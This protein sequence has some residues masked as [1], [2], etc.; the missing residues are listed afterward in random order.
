MKL[1]AVIVASLRKLLFTTAKLSALKALQAFKKVAIQPVSLHQPDDTALSGHHGFSTVKPCLLGSQRYRFPHRLLVSI[2][3]F[4]CSSG[5]FMKH[6][7]R[8]QVWVSE[9]V[10]PIT[11]VLF[12]HKVTWRNSESKP[13]ELIATDSWW[14]ASSTGA[15]YY[16]QQISLQ[17]ISWYLNWSVVE[18]NQH[19]EPPAAELKLNQSS[20]IN[21]NLSCSCFLVS[22]INMIFRLLER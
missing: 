1:G 3:C 4:Y 12:V 5:Y 9:C 13:F 18:T 11:S 20:P 21:K 2:K 16:P 19:Q 10:R 6:N 14:T 7:Q 8:I 17:L 22:D 15:P